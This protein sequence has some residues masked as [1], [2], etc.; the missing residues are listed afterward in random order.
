MA[1]AAFPS[2]VTAVVSLAKQAAPLVR[3]VRGRDISNDPSDVVMVGL[4]DIEDAG[5]AS[6]GTFRQTMQTFG[7]NRE[8]VGEVNG[9]V[10]AQSGGADQDAACTRAF[11]H[12]ALIEAAVRN[13]PT[14]GL[15]AFDYVVAEFQ[16][17]EVQEAQTDQGAA[18]A[19]SFS[20][21]YKIRI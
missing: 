15:T 3:V 20:V 18:S 16:A 6:A 13:G 21:A 11:A 2:V 19:V 10:V 7:G 17:G 5:W 4:R 8:E 12:L 1:T 14:L 9:L